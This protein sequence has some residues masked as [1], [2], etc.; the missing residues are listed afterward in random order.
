MRKAQILI[1]EDERIVAEEIQGGLKK[2][3]F[4]VSAIVSSGEEAI[5]KVKENNPDLVLMD[6]VLKGEMDGVE[7][8]SQIRTQFNIPIVYLTA[9]ADEELLER[10]KITEPFGYIIKPFE[11]RELKIAVELALYKAKSEM[12]EEE[13]SMYQDRLRSM[14]LEL[15][16][17]EEKERRRIA[18]ELHDRIGQN[19]ALSHNKL[20]NLIELT[21]SGGFAVPL[22]EIRDLIGQSMK[23]TKTLIFDLSPPILYELGL[24]AA[25]EWLSE[26]LN[27]Q[28][29]IRIDFENDG[30]LKPLDSYINIVL[31]QA[32]RELLINVIKH[33][34]AKKTKV[35]I[36]KA[37]KD[38]KIM[39]EDDG[40]G[41]NISSNN[42]QKSKNT[43]FGLFSISERI[44]YIG[45]RVKVESEQWH[46]TKVT[47]VLPLKDNE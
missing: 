23:E 20:E 29:G 31:F 32:V 5:K 43:G 13:I 14:A 11:D 46:G 33:A 8:A 12:A 40:K 26:H 7:T 37:G 10:A 15:S 30:Q 3:G 42:Y 25:L 21:E 35:S 6:I 34:E 28:Y 27:T 24:E 2:M 17:I 18:K 9:Y 45:G 39:V 47:M 22:K 44:N 1:V 36:M 4:A 38:I 41:F 16:L 19:L